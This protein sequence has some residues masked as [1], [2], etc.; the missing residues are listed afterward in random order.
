MESKSDL[1]ILSSSPSEYT[2]GL[3]LMPALPP[4]NGTSTQEH[5][6]QE[7]EE[8]KDIKE[9]REGSPCKS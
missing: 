3:I 2:L 1:V 4:P 8:R 6:E 5:W 9:M 7:E